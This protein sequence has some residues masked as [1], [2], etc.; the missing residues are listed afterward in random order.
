LSL[1]GILERYRR[2][3]LY[4]HAYAAYGRLDDP[5]PRTVEQVGPDQRRIFDLASLTKALATVPLVFAQGLPFDQTV[6]DWAPTLRG[7]LKPELGRL[8]IRA[9]LRHEAG[10]PAWRNFWVCR[11]GD[12][13]VDRV[14]RFE[15]ILESLNRLDPPLPAR[16]VYSDLGFLLLGLVLEARSG[17]PLA[18]QLERLEGELV[19]NPPLR[20]A[21]IPTAYCPSR[22]RLLVG[23]VH[24]ENCAALG[25][26][27]G[28]AGLFGS[29]EAVC[30]FLHRYIGGTPEGRQLL[31]A[32]AAA[33]VLPP[34]KDLSQD[35]LLGWRQG[36]GPSTAVFGGGGAVGHPGFTGT[37][38]WIDPVRRDYVVVLTNRIL[39]GRTDL[40]G[41][42]AARR[43]I[44]E[45]L[46]RGA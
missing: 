29:G 7:R 3:G 33:V 18:E 23:E 6:F 41:I 32:Q 13:P 16:Q 15:W 43:E 46:A 34:P 27:A 30:S 1:G 8:T 31:T 38:F 26:V 44:H 39:S 42:A 12:G 22:G 5:G 10:L 40:A 9:L 37:S 20:T 21:C 2:L 4:S 11:L 19:Y 28:H 36:S 24:D 35:S 25:G 17:K 14:K 45:A